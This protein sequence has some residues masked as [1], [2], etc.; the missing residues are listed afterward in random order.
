VTPSSALTAGAA[1]V[2]ILL[3]ACRVAP[4]TGVG[5]PRRYAEAEQ[6]LREALA[7]EDSIRPDTFPART[8]A[9]APLVA[10]G[11]DSTLVALSYGLAD[12]LLTDLA[13]SRQL[14]IVE[15]A[16]VD[17]ALREQ[18]LVREGRVDS[19]TAPRLGRI[20]GARRV[21]LGVLARTPSGVGIDT[22]I[23]DVPSGQVTGGFSTV[24]RL[25]DILAAEKELAFRIFAELGVTLAPA[26]R[27]LVAQRP[28]GSLAALVAYGH[29]VREEAV[30]RYDAAATEYQRALRADPSFGLAASRL[31][32]LLP[33]RVVVAPL[34]TVS[35]AVAAAASGVNPG[36]LNPVVSG[37]QPGTTADVAFPP[38]TVTIVVQIKTIP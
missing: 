19:A 9:V 16:R 22:R 4:A 14:A 33:A 8:L 7:R 20:L 38:L 36:I 23:V 30:G 32:G 12:I 35:R 2:A 34:P 25:D 17:V 31:G 1:A 15:R 28:T 24:A 37:A 3:A 26:E 21:V 18:R 6:A 13:R 5:T 27:A 11:G 10:A 29:A